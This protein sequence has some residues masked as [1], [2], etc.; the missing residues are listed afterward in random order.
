MQ[1]KHSSTKQKW[2]DQHS[3]G[4]NKSEMAYTLLLIYR[5]KVYD[6]LI[7]CNDI[8]LNIR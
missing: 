8:I 7:L 2:A 1:Q 5:L 6:L 4:K 3:L